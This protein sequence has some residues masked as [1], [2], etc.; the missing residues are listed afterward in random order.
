MQ[1]NEYYKSRVE[2]FTRTSNLL[3]RKENQ[4]SLARLVLFILSLVLFYILFSVSVPTAVITL[5]IGLF[6]LG[7]LIKY[8]NGIIKKKEYYEHLCTIN[9]LELKSLAGDYSSF[10][11]GSVQVFP[12][13]LTMQQ[14]YRQPAY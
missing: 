4:L 12:E 7:W 8:Q 5:V 1:L 9:Q 10:P 2:E 11:A 14:A 13:L 6:S 3:K